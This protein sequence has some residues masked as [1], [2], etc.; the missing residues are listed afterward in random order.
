MTMKRLNK[1]ILR[2]LE[3]KPK[4]TKSVTYSRIGLSLYQN[5]AVSYYL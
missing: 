1:Q 4:I 5:N 2:K 3:N